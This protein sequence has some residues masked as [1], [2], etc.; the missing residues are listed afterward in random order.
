M[1]EG[2]NLLIGSILI[3]LNIVLGF[4]VYEI[5]DHRIV[6]CLNDCPWRLKSYGIPILILFCWPLGL[7]YFVVSRMIGKVRRLISP[8]RPI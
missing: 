1:L 3:F 8:C 4:V 7:T 5:M 6:V 2:I